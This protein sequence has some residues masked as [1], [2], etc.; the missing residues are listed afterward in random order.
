MAQNVLS[1]TP[2]TTSGPVGEIKAR[3][4]GAGQDNQYSAQ[5]TIAEG[6]LAHY[7][8]KARLA[9]TYNRGFQKDFGNKVQDHGDT[10][11]LRRIQTYGVQD[12]L[13][14]WRPQK[15]LQELVTLK[16][17]TIKGIQTY[18][19]WNDAGLYGNDD[20]EMESEMARNESLVYGI[21]QDCAKGY[22]E[23]L[24]MGFTPM[25]QSPSTGTVSAMNPAAPGKD[26]EPR[27]TWP[28][29]RLLAFM[30]AELEE[31]GLGGRTF[32]AALDNYTSTS[33]GRTALFTQQYGVGGAG[34]AAQSSGSLDGQMVAGWKIA[35]SSLNGRFRF[36]TMTN[37]ATI[38]TVQGVAA[39]VRATLPTNGAR[40]LTLNLANGNT[41]TPGTRFS[42]AGVY[43]VNTRTLQP[44]GTL[45]QFIVDG[46]NTGTGAG[47]GNTPRGNSSNQATVHFFPPMR[48]ESGTLP[49]RYGGPATTNATTLNTI[50][51][52]L[53]RR[54]CSQQ[55]AV[56][57][58]VL[59]MDPGVA[60]PDGSAAPNNPNGTTGTA[61]LFRTGI[62]GK[63]CTRSFLMAQDAGV[64][65]YAMPQIDPRSK[66]LPYVKATLEGVKLEAC[67]AIQSELAPQGS[68]TQGE[69]PGMLTLY[70]AWT[71]IGVG[72][73][74]WEA[75]AMVT[76][77]SVG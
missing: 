50:S 57:A 24:A 61:P 60:Q 56:G 23:G 33:F 30:Q 53:R 47:N 40:H 22:E 59:I 68:S 35:N 55:P 26:N 1:T 29:N 44:L 77:M 21:E 17:D 12:G 6:I 42:I 45:Q 69:R 43:A 11:T 73:P 39:T 37:I 27:G 18:S 49:P 36:G 13:S 72:V 76:G 63:Q 75:G 15:M 3:G 20:Y 54:N 10:L 67:I 64:L 5:A 52:D 19:E 25:A 2:T 32:H 70:Q 31:R 51:E 8:L 65:I 41:L 38:S 66:D 9:P 4:T 46:D 74:E 34:A 28:D 14:N 58:E 7:L 16:V 48:F 71:R 62:S